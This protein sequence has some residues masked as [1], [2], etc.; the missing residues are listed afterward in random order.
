MTVKKD[1]LATLEGSYYVYEWNGGKGLRICKQR[2]RAHQ[3]LRDSYLGIHCSDWIRLQAN[4]NR[5]AFRDQWYD[6]VS[7]AS[8]A[9]VQEGTRPLD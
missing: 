1:T 6:H 5:S 9:D 2:L 8:G 3:S 7:V 4:H